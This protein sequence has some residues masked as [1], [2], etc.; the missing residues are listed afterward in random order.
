M[1]ADLECNSIAMEDQHAINMR[2]VHDCTLLNVDWRNL[3]V[4]IFP[5][6]HMFMVQ[7]A[8][9]RDS[10]KRYTFYIYL[11]IICNFIIS[12][13]Y[14]TLFSLSR[15]FFLSSYTKNHFHFKA[16]W[17]GQRV[18]LYQLFFDFVIS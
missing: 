10:H 12:L 2:I 1:N 14:P 15:I 3:P 6:H 16:F 7:Q 18:S 8:A 9:A 11:Y 5:S 13:I 4:Y 17:P